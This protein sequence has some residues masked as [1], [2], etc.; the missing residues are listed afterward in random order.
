MTHARRLLAQNGK[1]QLPTLRHLIFD[2]SAVNSVDITGA[3]M[4]VDLVSD[5]SRAAGGPVRVPSALSVL[6]P[7]LSARRALRWA[8]PV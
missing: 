2:F 5:A 1:R 3:Q 6:S 7:C 8:R 4:L